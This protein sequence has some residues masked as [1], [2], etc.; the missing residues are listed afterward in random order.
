MARCLLSVAVYNIY[1]VASMEE[2]MTAEDLAAQ[3]DERKPSIW[4]SDNVCMAAKKSNLLIMYTDGINVL[5]NG[6]WAGSVYLHNH[7]AWI[8]SHGLLPIW[9][10]LYQC[11]NL[12]DEAHAKAYFDRKDNAARISVTQRDNRFY[13]TIDKVNPLFFILYRDDGNIHSNGMVIAVG[14]LP[15]KP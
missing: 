12:V 11:R 7:E 10:A 3:L 1:G 15:R 13:L 4:P 14:D 2:I 8:D 5:F 9:G 6:A